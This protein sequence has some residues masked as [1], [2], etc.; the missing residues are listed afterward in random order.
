MEGRSWRRAQ[1]CSPANLEIC[2]TAACVGA[3]TGLGKVT[4]GRKLGAQPVR[5]L[6]DVAL[7]A[8]SG[9]Y[10]LLGKSPRRVRAPKRSLRPGSEKSTQ[11]MTP[12]FRRMFARK[13]ESSR[14]CRCHEDSSKEH[15]SSRFVYE[16][17]QCIRHLAN[18]TE[19]QQQGDRLWMPVRDTRRTTAMCLVSFLSQRI[20][21]VMTC[22]LVAPVSK[23]LQ[24]GTA[25]LCLAGK[26]GA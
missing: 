14:R 24:V 16:Q 3:N 15:G 6:P 25:E 19:S 12:C 11:E 26:K 18:K 8:C 23:P 4:Q 1:A 10:P 22:G 20:S 5:Q 2:C 9:R 17:S 21:V 7:C 13:Q